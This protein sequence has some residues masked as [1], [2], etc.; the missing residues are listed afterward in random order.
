VLL[1]ESDALAGGGYPLLLSA[2]SNGF[3]G[4]LLGLELPAR[5]AASVAAVADGGALGCRFVRGGVVAGGGRVCRTVE[6][7]LATE[8]DSSQA[9]EPGARA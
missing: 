2:S 8:L 4:V 3:K 9:A 6:A 7:M 1:R 5:R